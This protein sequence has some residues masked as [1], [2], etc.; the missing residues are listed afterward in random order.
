M[1]AILRIKPPA[2]GQLQSQ[3]CSGS[4]VA[5]TGPLRPKDAVRLSE[6]AITAGF[7]HV[8]NTPYDFGSRARNRQFLRASL[9][10]H[11]AAVQFSVSNLESR[12]HS[13]A[14]KY[15]TCEEHT[16]PYDVI[17]PADQEECKYRADRSQP[18]NP[19]VAGP[20]LRCQ[21]TGLVKLTMISVLPGQADN[22]RPQLQWTSAA[23]Q[24]V[25]TADSDAMH[26]SNR[27]QTLLSYSGTRHNGTECTT[28]PTPTSLSQQWWIRVVISYRGF[29]S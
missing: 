6:P 3:P 28:L 29:F 23:F 18:K 17:P 2:P 7:M 21:K 5:R 16:A 13:L 27:F 20:L 9:L 26:A 10:A 22:S 4:E 19:N 12:T 15:H 11:I 8:L 25:S 1:S 14:C 24:N